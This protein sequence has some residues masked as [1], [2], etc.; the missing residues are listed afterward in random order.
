MGTHG[1]GA[2]GDLLMGSVAS[3]VLH[4]ARVPVTFVK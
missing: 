2:L 3:Q 4:H 1:R